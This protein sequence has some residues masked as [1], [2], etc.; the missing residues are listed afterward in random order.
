MKK[1]C[2]LSVTVEEMEAAVM[3]VLSRLPIYPE[4]MLSESPVPEVHAD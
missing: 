2:I 4:L 1:K 3:R